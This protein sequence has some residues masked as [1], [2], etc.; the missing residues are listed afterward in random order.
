MTNPLPQNQEHF[1]TEQT[2][3]ADLTS[4]PD[5]TQEA[6]ISQESQRKQQNPV[7]QESGENV[8]EP[9]VDSL[10]QLFQERDQGTGQKSLVS[11][12]AHEEREPEGVKAH[13]KDSQPS[14]KGEDAA[15]KTKL[16]LKNPQTSDHE[17]GQS[18]L[19]ALQQE[20]ARTQKRLTE[21]QQY[22]RHNAQRLKQALKI[23]QELVHEGSLSEEEALK[24][25]GA[26]ESEISE[27][28]EDIGTSDPHPFTRILK[29]ANQE[30]ENIR[31]YTEDTS[32]D[33]KVR[34]FDHFLVIAS[35]KD[36]E[37]ALEELQEVL[38]QP[39]ALA[40]K[41][42][43]L[44]QQYQSSYQAMKKAGGL[45]ALLEQKDQEIAKLEK[46]LDK[47]TQKLSQYED[48]D[49]PRYRLEDRGPIGA[50][51]P[52]KDTVSSLFDERD[53]VRPR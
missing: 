49:T 26:L 44:G 22:G 3:T 19:E 39:L 24:L 38:D 30:L 16:T 35:P 31:R 2:K 7:S 53:R 6:S 23:T 4:H 41:M 50:E 1:L 17:K 10:A 5:P 47:L 29:I 14:E 40:K 34:A 13:P 18:D 52:L 9:S 37:Q 27:T 48:Y 45:Q 43:A 36:Q 42:L 51:A 20:L 32:L 25:K 46:N 11:K 28:P 21:N 33:D 15:E 12:S 8:A